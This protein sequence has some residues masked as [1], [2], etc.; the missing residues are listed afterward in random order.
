MNFQKKHLAE[1]LYSLGIDE[2]FLR[3]GKKP[4]NYTEKKLIIRTTLKLRVSG[5]V[6][7]TNKSE[8]ETHSMGKVIYNTYI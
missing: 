5:H 4:T 7:S 8:K 1:Y 6:K 3:Q 2:D